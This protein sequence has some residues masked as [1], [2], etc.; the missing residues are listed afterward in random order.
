MEPDQSERDDK[1]VARLLEVLGGIFLA[2]GGKDMLTALISGGSVSTGSVVTSF[3][4][5][6]LLV[7]GLFWHRMRPHSET[8]FTRS[9]VG[10]ASDA[11]SWYFPL[12]AF[13]LYIMGTTILSEVRQNNEI[14]SLRNDVQ[15]MARVIE[16]GVLPRHLN[17]RQQ[18]AISNF[19][20]QFEPYEFAFKLP[21]EDEEASRY[22][23]DI[24]H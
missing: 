10:L 4:G 7:C 1:A 8:W 9:L 23:A 24:E 22:R 6:T 3:I 14:L 11:R 17:K 2:V 18:L 21:H 19:L 12:L 20:L 5:V 16:R 13:G 15:S